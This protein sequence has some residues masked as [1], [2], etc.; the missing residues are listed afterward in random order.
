MALLSG[1]DSPVETGLQSR[2]TRVLGIAYASTGD[3][4]AIQFVFSTTG[5][6]RVLI[7]QAVAA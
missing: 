5:R 1:S 3:F 2:D 6:A 7:A 4:T